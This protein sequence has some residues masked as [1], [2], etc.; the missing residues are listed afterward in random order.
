MNRRDLALCV[1]LAGLGVLSPACKK[2]PSKPPATP[3]PAVHAHAAIAIDAGVAVA[4]QPPGPP[5]E[6]PLAKK[7]IHP[8]HLRPFKDVEKYIAFL[9]RP[10]RAVWQKPDAVVEA[11][12]LRGDETVVDI[13]AGSG[14]F[15]FRFAAKLP[16]GKV[17]AAD[18][19]PEMVRHIHHKTMLESIRNVHATLIEPSD[20]G[21]PGDAD[22]VFICDVLHH[23]PD[24]AQWLA[25]LA[26]EMKPGARLALI[27]FKEGK[28]PQGPPENVKIPRAKLIDS[29]AKAGLVLDKE[30]KGLLPYQ[31]FL[32][33]KKPAARK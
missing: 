3:Q 7:G 22:M 33:F 26:G 25:K 5:I 32:T 19:D 21:V 28:L 10:D 8:D 13:G 17:V 27:E 9:E 12:G 1:S 20:P 23:V 29:V 31:V 24:R 11:L 4:Q 15:A 6:C 16:R 30:H 2:K 18:T 14:Y